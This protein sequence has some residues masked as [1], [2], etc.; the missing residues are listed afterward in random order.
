MS[1][2]KYKKDTAKMLIDF[3]FTFDE[4]KKTAYQLRILARD[5]ASFTN[6]KKLS[7]IK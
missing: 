3:G 6:S 7:M 5:L 4:A 1:E 2:K